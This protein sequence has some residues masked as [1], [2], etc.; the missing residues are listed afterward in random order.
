M[1]KIETQNVGYNFKKML[2]GNFIQ[3]KPVAYYAQKF[4]ISSSTFN[5]KVK[6]VF[7][8][9]P[10]KL[11]KESIILEAKKKLHLTFASIKEIGFDLGLRM[12]FISVDSSRKR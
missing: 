4:C 11:I 9:L 1:L 12:N 6:A 8:K 2:E 7:Y 3:Y 5:K 10:S